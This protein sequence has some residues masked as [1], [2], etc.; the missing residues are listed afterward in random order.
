MRMWFESVCCCL[1]VVP[2][3][4]SSCSVTNVRMCPQTVSEDVCLL[5]CCA[6]VHLLRAA[7]LMLVLQP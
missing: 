6:V 4:G 3:L 5:L 7:V 2:C 1:T